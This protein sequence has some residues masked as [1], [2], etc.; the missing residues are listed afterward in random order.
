MASILI[1]KTLVLLMYIYKCKHMYGVWDIFMYGVFYYNIFIFLIITLN[2]NYQPGE[3]ALVLDNI[4]YRPYIVSYTK[5]Q[6][7]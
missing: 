4:T 1:I 7:K 5:V 6:H 3:I 2:L